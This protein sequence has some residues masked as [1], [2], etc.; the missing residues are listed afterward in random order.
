VWYFDAVV[1]LQR[2]AAALALDAGD[3]PAAR[4]WLAA[5]DA[6]MRWSGASLGLSESHVLWAHCHR[7][8]RDIRQAYEHAMRA[9]AHASAPRQPLALAA[10][11][12]LIGDLDVDARRFESARGHYGQSLALAT[13]CSAPYERALTLLSFANLHAATGN[14]TDAAALVDE[15]RAIC[16]PLGAMPLLARIET[17]ATRITALPAAAP[18]YPDGLSAREV[19]VLRL[20]ATGRNNQEIADA[21]SLSVRTVERHITNLYARIDARG[22]AD[23]TAYALRHDI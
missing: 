3:L 12:R 8:A 17:L 5:H 10:A 6:W 20:I 23:A 19:D 1:K 16:T 7:Q 11:H 21:L 13:A 2:E 22:R 15:V 18:T 14:P 4:E 9:L